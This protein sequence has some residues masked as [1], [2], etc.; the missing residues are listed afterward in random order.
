MNNNN[1]KLLMLE[2][3]CINTNVYISSSYDGIFQS[4]PKLYV[5]VLNKN[6]STREER[7]VGGCQTMYTHD[8]LAECTGRQTHDYGRR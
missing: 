4:D 5:S 2:H 6:L 1:K 8:Y 7:D 3:W